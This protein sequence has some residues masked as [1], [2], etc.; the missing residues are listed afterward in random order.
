MGAEIKGVDVGNLSDDAFKEVEDALFRHKMIYLRNQEIDAGVLESFSARFGEFADD[1]Y[2]DGIDGH[3]NV[4]PIIKE[5]DVKTGWVFGAGWHTDS[6]FLKRPPAISILY[7][8]DIPPY[9][10]DTVWANSALAYRLLSPAMKDLIESLKVHMSMRDV[11]VGAQ[12]KGNPGDD[13]IGKLVKLRAAAELPED[14]KEKI[15][16]AYHPLVR[17][18]PVSGEKCLYVDGSYAINFEGFAEE[19]AAP[20][21]GYLV[22]H[23]TQPAFMCRL[24]WEPKTL[25]LWDNRLCIHQALN[26]YDGFRREMYRTTIAGEAPR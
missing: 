6:P 19:E 13:P 20:I 22:G 7:G 4:Q 24:R 26:D 3:R 17:T 18:H 23:I 10:G 25:T 15:Q 1:A 2:T 11:L 16:G 12:T 14:L 5:A 21:I 8:V 9:G